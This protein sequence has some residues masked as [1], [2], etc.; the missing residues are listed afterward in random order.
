LVKQEVKGMADEEQTNSK[1]TTE[2]ETQTKES[3]TLTD[4]NEELISRDDLKRYGHT[5]KIFFKK[6][7][8]L[9]LLLIPIIVSFMFRLQPMYLPEAEKWAYNQI[10]SQLESQIGNQ[11]EQQYPNLPPEL[12]QERINTELQTQRQ[13]FLNQFQQQT[14]NL[15][16]QYKSQLQDENGDPYLLSIDPF[17]YL[18]YTRNVIEHGYMGDELREGK[19]YDTLMLAP[20]GKETGFSFLPYFTAYLYKFATFF[21]KDITVMQMV[22]FVPVLIITLAIIPIFFIGRKL[23]GNLAGFLA[24]MFMNL[25]PTTMSRS[26]WGFYDTDG[27]TILL[28]LLVIWFFIEAFDTENMKKKILFLGFSA[29]T[30]GI[31]T[32]IWTG[33]W[34][35]IY[36]LVGSTLI[37][38]GYTLFRSRKEMIQ[39]WKEKEKTLKEKTKTFLMHLIWK[40]EEAKNALI[41]VGLF[42]IVM[43]PVMGMIRGK[44]F[45]EYLEIL[46]FQPFY[47]V[48]HIGTAVKS[49]GELW[50]NVYVT[51]AELSKISYRE[52]MNAT[53]GWLVIM[54]VMIA[55]VVLVLQYR[56]RLSLFG[57][58]I[59]FLWTLGMGYTTKT[60]GIRFLM[61]LTSPIALGYGIGIAFLFTLVLRNVKKIVPENAHFYTHTKSIIA[62]FLLMMIGLTMGISPFPPFCSSG[63]CE[64]AKRVSTAQL[65]LFD[66]GW[67]KTLNKIKQESSPDAIINSWWDF[68]HWFKAYANRKVIFDGASQNTPHAYWMS[69]ALS[70]TSEQETM[71]VLRMLNCGSNTAYKLVQEKKKDHIATMHILDELFT[72]KK[73][74]ARQALKQKHFTD[75]E[76]QA[77]MDVLFCIPKE[78]YMITSYDMVSKALMWSKL[79]LWDFEKA[80]IWRDM[81]NMPKESSITFMQEKLNYSS[82]KAE[83]IYNEIAGFTTEDEGLQWIAQSE[84]YS[85]P[86]ACRKDDEQQKVICVLGATD[87]QPTLIFETDLKTKETHLANTEKKEVPQMVLWLEDGKL[88]QRESKT[89][90]VDATFMLVQNNDAFGAYL[91][92]QKIA[93]SMFN[94]LMFYDGAGL[95]YFEPYHQEQGII[96]GAI[97]TWKIKWN[98]LG[99]D[100]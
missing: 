5:G 90:V 20:I 74:Q 44:A 78:G 86:L 66:D 98:E 67:Y 56:K 75:E 94:I 83:G 65:P 79:G 51:V 97:K 27:F 54:L 10:D 49:E 55:L 91:V 13:N 34:I 43:I 89:N 14:Q 84:G 45:L 52:I 62:I 58:S 2:Q 36:I 16:Q 25:D 15:I 12:L 35:P 19:S 95:K 24:A 73:E 82:E 64:G 8:Y 41:T 26:I 72:L 22:S 18:R 29:V 69:R 70:S 93:L 71:A 53:G 33:W 7:G 42:F 17:Q 47:Y 21:K 1:Q 87:I 32:Y 96:T 9:V 99:R 81:R 46:F 11:L 63:I 59:I 30:T 80:L 3:I 50:P 48:G 76:T 23:G 88:Q 39:G 100:Y 31:F 6:Y 57:A 92:D 60:A 77:I 38:V 85:Q 28:P 4:E 68:G 40:K 37:H 61:N